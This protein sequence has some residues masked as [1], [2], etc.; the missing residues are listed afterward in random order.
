MKCFMFTLYLSM[1][2][3]FKR[4]KLFPHDKVK[5]IPL[6]YISFCLPLLE[7]LIYFFLYDFQISCNKCFLHIR[8]TILEFKLRY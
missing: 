1:K 4:E 6:L 2:D 3:S 7:V 5:F 8:K